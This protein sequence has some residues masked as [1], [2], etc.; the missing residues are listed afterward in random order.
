MNRRASRFLGWGLEI[1]VSALLPCA[2]CQATDLSGFEGRWLNEAGSGRLTWID[3]R[4]ND[5]PHPIILAWWSCGRSDGCLQNAPLNMSGDGQIQ[6][7]FV[8]EGRQ[9]V[10]QMRAIG[11][12]LSVVEH[13]GYTDGREPA[14]VVQH[15]FRRFSQPPQSTG[16][17][18]PNLEFSGNGRM[19]RTSR[20]GDSRLVPPP[21]V[22]A[23]PRLQP[24]TGGAPSGRDSR[25]AGV[26]AQAFE[27][28]YNPAD[29][30]QEWLERYNY[31]LLQ[32]L[33][34][35]LKPDQVDRYLNTMEVGPLPFNRFNQRSLLINEITLLGR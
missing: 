5:A 18:Q 21:S 7:L 25:A 15:R 9:S 23:Q 19:M 27:P 29:P 2:L 3:I 32:V 33:Y 14:I 26:S 13:F 12:G 30:G 31:F 10:L 20:P 24:S 1:W 6:V 8:D 34:Y 11:G 17:G 22:G 28:P 35:L 4:V 16:A